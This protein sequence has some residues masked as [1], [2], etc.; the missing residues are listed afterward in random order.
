MPSKDILKEPTP[1]E[2]LMKMIAKNYGPANAAVMDRALKNQDKQIDDAMLKQGVSLEDLAK[3]KGI[4]LNNIGNQGSSNQPAQPPAPAPTP[5][6]PPQAPLITK[7]PASSPFGFGGASMDQSGNIVEQK[8]G[9]VGALLQ[10]LLTMGT[11]TNLA[12][13]MNMMDMNTAANIQ[14]KRQR[15]QNLT[16]EDQISA[17]LQTKKLMQDQGIEGSVRMSSEGTP[18]IEEI[19]SSSKKI[20]D[21][22]FWQEHKAKR[23][24]N[25]ITDVERANSQRI[26]IKDAFSS[27][28]NI[29]GGL[30]GKITKDYLRNLSPDDPLLQDWQKVKLITMDATLEQIGKTKGAI[31]DR[32]WKTFLE[33]AAADDITSLPRIRP[34]LQKLLKAVNDNESSLKKSYKQIYGEDPSRFIESNIDQYKNIDF[35]NSTNEKPKKGFRVIGVR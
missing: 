20:Q 1:K 6:Q 22:P 30:R 19:L 14:G 13:K 5:A 25:L 35:N 28:K 3:T 10:G 31:S 15:R 7:Q 8:P 11:G 16:P 29:L 33:A 9:F 12:A 24:E 21:S 34:V 32:E 18:M 17:L 4:D 23:T 27:A 26:A 2:I